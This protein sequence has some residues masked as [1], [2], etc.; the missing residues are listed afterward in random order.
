MN[1]VL[2]ALNHPLFVFGNDHVSSAEIL[3]FITG[4]WCVWLTVKAKV[5]NFPVSIANSI[6]FLI[7]FFAARLYADGSLQI[8]Y[9]ALSVVGWYQWVYGGAGK[10]ALV[11]TRA[12]LRTVAVLMILGV[13][14]TWALT[15]L[16]GAAHDIAPLWDALTT[17]LSLVAQW[18]LNYKKVQNWYFWIVADLIYVP[19]YYVKHL[20]LT[21]I[22]YVCFLTMCFIG[23]A[24]WHRAVVPASEASS[25]TLV[26]LGEPA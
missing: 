14:A 8:I 15:L 17:A 16:L 25:L 21:A 18:L 24:L 19:L 3:G 2:N 4:I 26:D 23:L 20:D 10:T 12:S 1:T 5:S 9:I 13:F 6:F 7:L 22:V 11:T